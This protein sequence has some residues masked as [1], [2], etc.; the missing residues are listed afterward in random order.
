MTIDWPIAP[1]L[2]A[3]HAHYECANTLIMSR[4]FAI[5]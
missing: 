2:V 1:L 5:L 3:E 4:C